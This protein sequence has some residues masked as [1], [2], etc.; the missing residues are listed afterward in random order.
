MMSDESKSIL[1][2]EDEMVLAMS[3]QSVIE[4]MGFRVSGIAIS[5]EGAVKLAGEERP[6]LVLMDIT[7]DGTMDG[8]EAAGQIIEKFNIPILFVTGYSDDTT[9]NRL[10][11]IDHFGVLQKPVDEYTLKQAIQNVMKKDSR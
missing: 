11:S 10:N 5:G 8:I 6:D 4:N 7:L 3:M 2:V 1:I 9:L